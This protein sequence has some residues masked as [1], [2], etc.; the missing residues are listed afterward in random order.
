MDIKEIKSIVD[1]MKRSGL[2]EFQL[3]EEDFKIRI[4]RKSDEVQTIYQAT[5]PAPFPVQAAAATPPPVP[6]NTPP[7]EPAPAAEVDESKLIKSPMVGTFYTSPSPE[8][9]PFIKIGDSV[10]GDTVVCIV[11]A[12]KVMN[13]IK[14]ELKGQIAEILVDNGESVEYGQPLFRLK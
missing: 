5:T 4:C 13:E 8:S 1:L 6:Q 9:P 14:A 10:S 12:M 11:E 3:E 2:T 7:A